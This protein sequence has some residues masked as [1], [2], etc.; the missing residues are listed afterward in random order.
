M[1]VLLG[2]ASRLLSDEIDEIVDVDVLEKYRPSLAHLNV[3]FILEREIEP[4]A[5]LPGFS[6]TRRSRHEIISILQSVDRTLVFA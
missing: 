6:V 3:P 4:V 5:V 2:Q 1:V